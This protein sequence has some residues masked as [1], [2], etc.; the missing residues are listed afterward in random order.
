LNEIPTT[1][2]VEENTIK[3]GLLNNVVKISVPAHERRISMIPY[4]AWNNRGDTS[5]IVWLPKTDNQ[6]KK[7]T[8]A[9]S[10]MKSYKVT[11]SSTSK[12]HSPEGILM[13]ERPTSSSDNSVNPWI[14][15]N[16]SNSQQMTIYLG[17]EKLIRSISV[18]WYNNNNVNLPKK[19]SVDVLKDEKW[20]PLD[21]YVTD[22][23]SVKKDQY[24]M[25]HSG[26][27]LNSSA[28][29]I[30]MVVEKGTS[31]GISDVDIQ[32]RK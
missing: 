29:R 28:I 7:G 16:N 31:V 3:G 17:K 22:S 20:I 1:N 12:N 11:A 23:Y 19:W 21:I 5:M 15:G 30:N 18:Y 6:F 2:A 10:V 14:S 32:I 27:D 9:G 13:E 4:Y 8:P 26:S 24:N 25:I